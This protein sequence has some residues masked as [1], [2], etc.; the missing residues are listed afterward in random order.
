[1]QEWEGF[2]RVVS[3]G[4]PGNACE[5]RKEEEGKTV[6]QGKYSQEVEEQMKSFY[7]TLSEKEKRRYVAQPH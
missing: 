2:A 5:R 1:M 7:T 6:F 3:E 4:E